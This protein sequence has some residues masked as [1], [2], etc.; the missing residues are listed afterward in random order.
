LTG[1]RRHVDHVAAALVPCLRACVNYP[2]LT[3]SRLPVCVS[4]NRTGFAPGLVALQSGVFP[5]F[6]L[7]MCCAASAAG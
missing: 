1:I 4:A 2:R 6:W 7:R 3:A 5:V